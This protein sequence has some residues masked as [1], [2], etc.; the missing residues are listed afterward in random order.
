MGCRV[1]LDACRG[2]ETRKTDGVR[3]L[4]L[5]ARPLGDWTRRLYT[6][7]ADSRWAD[8]ADHDQDPTGLT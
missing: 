3:T 8:D 1:M 5:Y 2:D 4:V 7:V 6:E